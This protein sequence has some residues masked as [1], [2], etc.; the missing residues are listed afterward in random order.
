[1]GKDF[2]AK[3]LADSGQGVIN[4]SRG[5]KIRLT[6]SFFLNW[7]HSCAT[8]RYQAALSQAWRGCRKAMRVGGVLRGQK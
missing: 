2:A 6:E 7:I 1:M 3:A 4:C 8:K 5:S